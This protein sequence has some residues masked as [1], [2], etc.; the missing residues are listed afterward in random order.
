MR[1][2]LQNGQLLVELLLTI[3]LAALILPALLTGMVA[4]REGK[5]QQEQRQQAIALL[6]ETEAA[7]KSMRN[8]NWVAFSNITTGAVYHPIISGNQWTLSPGTASNSAGFTQSVVLNDVYRDSSGTIVSNPSGATLDPS[9]LKADLTVS[10]T[11]PTTSSISATMYLTRTTNLTN[12]DET[13]TEFDTGQYTNLTSFTG[14]GNDGAIRLS[15]NNKAKWCSPAFSSATLDLP[16]GPPVAVAA[17]ASA[18]TNT[19]PNDVYVATAP[20]T[21]SV[22]KLTHINVPADVATPSATLRGKFTM[23]ASQ[24]SGGYSPQTITGFDNNF[25][26]TD[27][28]YYK[29]SGGNTYALLGT[30]LASLEVVAVWVNDGNDSTNNE[31]QDPVN[32]IYK[33]K[34]FF[35]TKRYT[36]VATN[37]QSPYGYGAS[38]LAVLGDRGYVASGGYLYV[39]NLSN[40]DSKSTSSYLDMHGCRIQL[41]GYECNPGSPGT[42][43]KYSSGQSGTSWGD[44]TSPI[45]NDCSDGGNI[46][47]KATNDLAPVVVGSNQYVFTAIGGVTNPEFEIVNV[48]TVPSSSRSDDSSCGRISGGDSTWRVSG[49]LDFN[50]QSSTEEAANSV[51][52]RADGNRAYISSNGGIDGNSNGQADSKQFYVINTSSKTSPAFL[53]GSGTPSSGYYEGGSPA[54]AAAVEMYPRRSM[55]VL[56]GERA[57]LVGSDAVSNGNDAE[58]YQVLDMETEASP[59][60]CSGVDFDDGFNDLTYVSEKDYETYIYMIAN[61][62]ANEL[63]I[64]EGGPDDAIYVPSGSYESAIFDTASIDGNT[65]L[66]AF[67]RLL[68]NIYQPTNTSVEFQVAVAPPVGGSCSAAT[69]SYIGPGGT[70]EPSDTYSTPDIGTLELTGVIPLLNVGNYQNP[71]RCFRY[72][73]YMET[74]DQMISPELR[75]IYQNYSQ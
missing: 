52:A 26:T 25:K 12:S 42:A 34:T 24:F 70:T 53:S 1:M 11:V 75:D 73:V 51:F 68:A 21:S 33:V 17:T 58:E 9:T 22:V 66:R 74:L 27:V 72:K 71:G 15:N 47:L 5:P 50:N 67:N 69:F 64:I 31:F 20:N 28:V 29:S 35:N 54:P 60:Y 30:N 38:T 19:I 46:E 43:A 10:W 36:A 23:D 4:S 56:N 16:D 40:I 44:T 65:N 57:V 2:K 49:T 13:K 39:F 6:K 14:T 63:K 3:G 41:N 62:T 48:S 61:T 8:D 55:T 32:K 37:D 59:T 45:H 7:I 18:T